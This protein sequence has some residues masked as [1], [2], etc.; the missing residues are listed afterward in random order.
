MTR[1]EKSDKIWEKVIADTT[2]ALWHLDELN[3]GDNKPS[4]EVKGDEFDPCTKIAGCHH[5]TVHGVGSVGK[6]IWKD[7]GGHNFTGIFKGGDTGIVRLGSTFPVL[8][9]RKQMF[10]AMA[11]K[12]LRDGQDSGNVVSMVASKGQQ[13]LNFFENE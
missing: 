3:L 2:P 9:E 11:I 1:Q 5:K 4:L 10:P 12:I 8:P 7:L 6:V 13:S